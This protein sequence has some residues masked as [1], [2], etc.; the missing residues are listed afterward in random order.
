MELRREGAVWGCWVALSTV[1][2]ELMVSYLGITIF[3]HT[4]ICYDLQ[5]DTNMVLILNSR[6]FAA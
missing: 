1:M 6:L 2:G 5:V 3:M 4:Y